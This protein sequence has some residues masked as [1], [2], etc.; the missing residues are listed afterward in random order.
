MTKKSERRE[1][2]DDGIDVPVVIDD[3]NPPLKLLHI[4]QRIRQLLA[5]LPLKE[6][7]AS[8]T[9]TDIPALLH[10]IH[11]ILILY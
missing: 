4:Q 7:T 8:L 3:N 10:T 9:V 2:E 6:D 5:S 11:G 1:R